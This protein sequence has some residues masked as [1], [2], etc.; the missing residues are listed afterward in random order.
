MEKEGSY[1]FLKT[2][3]FVAIVLLANTLFFVY[4]SN[5]FTGFSVKSFKD[6]EENFS[7]LQNMNSKTQIFLIGQWALLIMLLLY[8]AVRD[9]TL[10]RGQR[11]N[12]VIN[13]STPVNFK[14]D[15]DTLYEILK[16]HKKVS[17]TDIAKSFNVEKDLVIE[18]FKIL[19]SGDL[20]EIYYPGFG[21]PILKLKE[22]ELEEDKKT[23]SIIS[24]KEEKNEVEKKFKADEKKSFDISALFVKKKDEKVNSL[25]IKRNNKIPLKSR[26]K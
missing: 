19:E 9:M 2:L 21:D 23:E 22:D 6:I 16:K 20:A 1:L 17:V 18:W 7:Y 4:K 13:Y 5:G 3:G 24:E 12:L 15:M 8:T 11:P 26:K 14:T 25:N 10:L